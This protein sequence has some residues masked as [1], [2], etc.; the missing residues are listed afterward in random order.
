MNMASLPHAE[1]PNGYVDMRDLKWS[2]SEKTIARKAFE[3][4]LQQELEEVIR[5]TKRRAAKIEQPP[6]LWD[7]A[8]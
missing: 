1:A 2:Q 6:D 4:A 7:K 5:E 8:S 3:H